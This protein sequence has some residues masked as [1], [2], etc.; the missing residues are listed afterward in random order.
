[1]AEAAQAAQKKNEKALTPSESRRIRRPSKSRS[2]PFRH[3]RRRPPPP[4]RLPPP[5]LLQA[6]PP[7]VSSSGSG[8]GGAEEEDEGI[9]DKATA[10]SA[11][12]SS[13]SSLLSDPDPD[14]GSADAAPK[15]GTLRGSSTEDRAPRTHIACIVQM[16]E[17]CSNP[18]ATATPRAPRSTHALLSPPTLTLD[19]PWISWPW[20][21]RRASSA[22]VGSTYTPPPSSLS[23]NRP[24]E[25]PS[26]PPPYA[27]FSHSASSYPQRDLRLSFISLA[28]GEP[29][30][31]PSSYLRPNLWSPRLRARCPRNTGSTSVRV[32]LGG[33][34]TRGCSITAPRSRDV[35][36][37]PLADDTAPYV[38]GWGGSSKAGHDAIR[39]AGREQQQGTT[40]EGQ[41][42]LCRRD[43][44]AGERC[45][46]TDNGVEARE[47]GGVLLGGGCTAG[48]CVELGRMRD[49][50]PCKLLSPL[51]DGIRSEVETRR[52]ATEVV[53]R[54]RDRELEAGNEVLSEFIAVMS[55]CRRRSRWARTL[56]ARPRVHGGG[57]SPREP[58]REEHVGRR[59]RRTSMRGARPSGGSKRELAELEM[60]EVPNRSSRPSRAQEVDDGAIGSLGKDC[61]AGDRAT[62]EEGRAPR[63][64]VLVNL[65]SKWSASEVALLRDG[66]MYGQ[67]GRRFLKRGT[68]RACRQARRMQRKI[69]LSRL[70]EGMAEE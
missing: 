21:A 24:R 27:A 41:G 25:T 30:R 17:R 2:F 7:R 67:L 56:G 62:A 16:L 45:R 11:F 9:F 36:G 19:N 4:S 33:A 42:H 65:K 26:A 55:V 63:D 10:A 13:S 51:D 38:L 64:V 40:L 23:A 32:R 8:S 37:A 49:P 43:A 5:I 50:K 6:P 3:M 15:T 54:D 53:A 57:R 48:R 14:L 29:R 39:G 60:W 58:F 35:V 52:V 59:A 1:M 47:C 61:G 70:E 34:G 68:R 31:P 46:A 44:N 28:V 12:T 69:A 20:Y 18:T 22:S 66:C